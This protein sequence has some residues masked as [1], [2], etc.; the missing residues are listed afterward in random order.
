MAPFVALEWGEHL[1]S[2]MQDIKKA[3][4]PKYIL[5]LGVIINDDPEVHLK[6][7]KQ[8]PKVYE[9]ID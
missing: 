9:S 8:L 3:F 6:N 1:Y 2:I 4:D 7:F 5:N